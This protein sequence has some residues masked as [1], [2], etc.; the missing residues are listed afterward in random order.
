MQL[1]GAQQFGE[2][3]LL[4]GQRGMFAADLH[5]LQLAQGAQPHVE[6]GFG[7]VVVEAE[8]LHQLGLGLILGADDLD[9]LVEVEEDREIAFQ[10]FQ[11]GGDLFQPELGA[12][13]QHHAAM[14]HKGLQHLLQ[15]HHARAP[16]RD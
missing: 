16:G 1:V 4:L 14:I 6:N 2:F 5:F 15:A 7:L 13:L 3:F 11:P 10:H 8:C 9:H 12:P